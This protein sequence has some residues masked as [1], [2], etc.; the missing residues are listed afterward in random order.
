M[1]P[2]GNGSL[3]PGGEAIEGSHAEPPIPGLTVKVQLQLPNGHSVQVEA[4]LDSGASADFIDQKL[5]Q[6]HK[7]ALLPLSFPLRVK[8]IDGR[9]LLSGEVTYET[10][11]MRM[12]MGHHSETRAF[13][14]TKLA[15]HPMVLGMS[16]L[17]C[18]NLV[19]AWHQR[20]LVFG[21]IYCMTHCL[22]QKGKISM[23]VMGTEVE[24]KL[25]GNESEIPSQYMAYQDVFCEKEADKLP[26]H[27]PYDC[28]IDLVPG[29]QLPPSKI[30]AMSEVESAALREFLQKNLQRGF[31]RE[32]TASGGAPV[33]FV[34][35]KG[36]EG[37]PRLVCDFR[38]LNSQMKPR[39][40][41]CHV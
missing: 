21:S 4:L 29:A 23:G 25:M 19:I 6:E 2:A 10:P 7:I 35:K 32:S 13:H 33:F 40:C 9:P 1:S 3:Q 18:H 20:S 12:D 34:K 37:A 41:H 39:V 11:P 27:R 30:Y 26:P 24:G 14:V 22:G 16:W 15:G 31:I 8:T 17:N 36:E 5:V 38:I 28:K